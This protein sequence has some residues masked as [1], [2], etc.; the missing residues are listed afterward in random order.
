[1]KKQQL[2]KNEKGAITLYVSIAC[3]FIMIIRNSEL[4]FNK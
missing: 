4:Y 3:L 2:L 1:M